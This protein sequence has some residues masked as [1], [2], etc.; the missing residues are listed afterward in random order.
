MLFFFFILITFSLFALKPCSWLISGAMTSAY[1]L[2]F[3]YLF[4]PPNGARS[5][6]ADLLFRAISGKSIIEHRLIWRQSRSKPISCS[7][8]RTEWRKV[9]E[10]NFAEVFLC[11]LW[12]W[13]RVEGAIVCSN[14][15]FYFLSQ[16]CILPFLFSTLFCSS[17]SLFITS[18]PLL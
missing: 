14:Q 5:Q 15:T 9:F 2:F 16:L 6:Y 1:G 11:T 12:L 10:F 7:N 3:F 8:P 18:W 17:S 4:Q 13:A